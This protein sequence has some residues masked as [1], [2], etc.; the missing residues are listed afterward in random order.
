M[1]MKLGTG[2]GLMSAS[3]PLSPNERACFWGGWGGAIC[4]IDLDLGLSV[5]YVMNKMAGGLVG[6]LRGGAPGAHRQSAPPPPSCRR[7]LPLLADG[8]AVGHGEQH[9]HHPVVAT[10]HGR[11][12]PAAPRC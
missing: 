5:A 3:I 12:R 8:E 11:C 7:R 9:G 1:A 6:D 2:F 10:R 4:V